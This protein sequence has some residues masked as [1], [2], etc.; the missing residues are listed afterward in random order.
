MA[1]MAAA[2]QYHTAQLLPATTSACNPAQDSTE[3]WLRPTSTEVQVR[4]SNGPSPPTCQVAHACIVGQ[5]LAPAALVHQRLLAEQELGLGGGTNR[6]AEQAQGWKRG[7]DVAVAAAIRER[8]C[9]GRCSGREGKQPAV[10][11]CTLRHSVAG[12]PR[13]VDKHKRLWRE[14]AAGGRPTCLETLK[15]AGPRRSRRSSAAPSPCS[16]VCVR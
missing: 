6:R 12:C 16:R 15:A 8:Q 2:G 7:D 1:E 13:Q 3:V 5:V 4:S 11:A 10:A 14:R 9:K